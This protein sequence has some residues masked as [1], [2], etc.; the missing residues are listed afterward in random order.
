[1]TAAA[2]HDA[3]RSAKVLPRTHQ[4]QLGTLD[5]FLAAHPFPAVI[6]N[7]MRQAWHT[8]PHYFFRSQVQGLRRR[9]I[10]EPGS[11]VIQPIQSIHLHFGAALAR[12]LEVT[13]RR[14]FEGEPEPL[15]LAA[16]AEALITAWGIADPPAPTN[17]NEENKTLE[18]CLHAH[19]GY[20]REFALDDPEHEIASISGEPLV[21]FSGALPIP[22]CHHPITGEP[23]LY[24]GRFDAICLRQGKLWGL[25][26][27]STGSNIDSA[28]W[29]S[30]W[31]LSGQFTGYCWLAEGWGHRLDG[32]LVHGIQVLK[33]RT[34]YAE[35]ISPRPRYLI[36]AWLRQLST[37]VNTMCDQYSRFIAGH[38]VREDYSIPSAIAHPFSRAYGSAC[39]AYNHP[40]AYLEDLCAQPN[41]EDWLDNFVVER[42]DPLRRS[43]EA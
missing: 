19:T 27:K 22:A 11:E 32:F 39:H 6:D 16:G 13:R 31:T 36:D 3:A 28:S 23:I 20:F 41:P 18:N 5:A 7:T 38:Q 1:M 14:W 26:D 43:I 40:C 17:R 33:D 30:Q 35:A 9:D 10:G 15:A 24:A 37:D 34:K 4:I 29:R 42:W 12:G 2:Q 21:E 8:C 25:D